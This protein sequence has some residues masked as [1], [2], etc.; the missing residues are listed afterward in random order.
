MAAAARW[1]W[2]THDVTGRQGSAQGYSL[3]HGWAPAFPETTGYVIGTLI[4]YGRLVGEPEHE[5]R[6]IEM[7]D[8]EIGVQS[9]DGG[10][11][12]GVVGPDP[13]PTITFNTGMVLHGF[14]DLHAA[15]GEARFLD[16]GRR[17]GRFLV[18]TL[19]ADG[20]W[21]GEHT[22]LGLPHT[23]K[24][25]VAWAMLRLSEATGDP[26]YGDGARRHLAWVLAQQQPNGWFENCNFKPGGLPNTHG[27]AYTLRG[28]LESHAITGDGA[29]LEAV[30]RTSERLIA[31]LERRGR[32]PAVY[33]REWE[34]AARYECNT[35]TVQLGNV[36]MRLFEITGEQRYLDAGVRA[37]DQAAS[38]QERSRWPAIDGALSGSFPVYGRYSPLRYPNWVT[39]FLLDALIRR[40]ELTGSP[41]S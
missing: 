12:Q 27:I 6:A 40:R 20:A 2:R 4:N 34:P 41:E 18:D 35:G 1:L 36:W 9:A 16:A 33:D 28:L 38:R 15:T 21:R 23:Y 32:L 13:G 10:I 11:I 25:R 30:V 5:R 31:E 17:A 3:L 26:E 29:Y 7:G 37:T 22:Y 24:S 14:V 8:W 39:K 19:D